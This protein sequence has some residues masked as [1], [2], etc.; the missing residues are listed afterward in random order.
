MQVVSGADSTV[1]NIT[2]PRFQKNPM[3]DEIAFACVENAVSGSR[4][5]TMS[6]RR[7]V[8]Q[9][10]RSSGEDAIVRYDSSRSPDSGKRK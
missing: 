6:V 2:A 5:T 3:P 10:E 4:R 7:N 1:L 8:R 9:Q